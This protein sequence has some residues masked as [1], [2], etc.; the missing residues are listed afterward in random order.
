MLGTPVPLAPTGPG[1]PRACPH[2]SGTPPPSDFRPPARPLRGRGAARLSPVGR[3]A[4]R[5]G[6]SVRSPGTG[7]GTEEEGRRAASRATTHRL[8]ARPPHGETPVPPGG[9]TGPVRGPSRPV[10][11]ASLGSNGGASLGSYGGESLGRC[12]VK[13]GSRGWVPG[14]SAVRS[15][16]V[17]GETAGPLGDLACLRRP[18]SSTATPVAHGDRPCPG[19]GAPAV[20]RDHPDPP[21][22]TRP[23]EAPHP[24][25]REHSAPPETTP[26]APPR[27]GAH[28]PGSPR[29][30]HRA[31]P[32]Q[33]NRTRDGAAG[34]QP[35][36]SILMRSTG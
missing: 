29:P 7:A 14:P 8:G 6:P 18:G 22:A 15:W 20:W 1:P 33:G 26:A 27:T 34:R 2:G 3:A 28:T 10:R 35:K 12:G 13:P 5:T 9:N 30:S 16:P 25:R 11:G 4:G 17:G 24:V 23:P 36:R 31:Q 19:H 21:E 32:P